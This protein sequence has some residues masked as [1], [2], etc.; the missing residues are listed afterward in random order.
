MAYVPP[1]MKTLT[2]Y[3]RGRKIRKKYELGVYT[4][5]ELQGKD[6]FI[7]L[8]CKQEITDKEPKCVETYYFE[9]PKRK[10]LF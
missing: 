1:D 9:M 5:Y 6:D 3:L 10:K 4:R 2:H 7:I 8:E